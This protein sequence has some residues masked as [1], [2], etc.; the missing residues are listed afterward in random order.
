MT[1]LMWCLPLL[2]ASL[3]MAQTPTCNPSMHTDSNGNVCT[4]FTTKGG[5][6][7]ANNGVFTQHITFS[8][9]TQDGV[10]L[11]GNQVGALALN[12]FYGEGTPDFQLPTDPLITMGLISGYGSNLLLFE[13]GSLLSFITTAKAGPP[14]LPF[15]NTYVVSGSDYDGNYVW[16]VTLAVPYTFTG[17][18]NSCGRHPCPVYQT[19]EG[20]GEASAVPFAP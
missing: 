2:S 10:A 8:V 20:A 1:K 5:F 17:R 15:V 6:Q 9:D 12:G 11:T 14:Y 18:I 7:S 16:T 19:G 13:G 3:A 4:N